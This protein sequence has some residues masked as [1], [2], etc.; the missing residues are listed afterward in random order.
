[1]NKKIVEIVFLKD[2]QIKIESGKIIAHVTD[3][4]AFIMVKDNQ[5]NDLTRHYSFNISEKKGKVKI[6]LS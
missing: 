1:M 4:P 3:F 2:T 5:G 6:N